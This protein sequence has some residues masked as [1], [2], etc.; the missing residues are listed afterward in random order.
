MY[1]RQDEYKEHVNNNAYTNYMAHYNMELALKLIRELREQEPV[2]YTGL[3]ARLPLEE[4]ER[5]ISEKLDLIYLP[6]PDDRGLIPQ[7]DGYFGLREIDLTPYKD[8]E[9]VGTI[10]NDYNAEPVSYTHLDVYKRQIS[11]SPPLSTR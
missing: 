1:K 4:T 7:F 5:E 3:C 11:T 10:Y 9:T 6:Q 8:R 2:F